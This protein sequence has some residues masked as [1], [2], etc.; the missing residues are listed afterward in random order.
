MI[1]DEKDNTILIKDG[2]IEKEL[3]ILFTYHHEERN[4]DYIFLYDE[5]TPDDII[6]CQYFDDGSLEVIEDEEILGEAQEILDAYDDELANNE[7]SI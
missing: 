2:D 7:S 1:I 5:T 3:K 6:L 4:S